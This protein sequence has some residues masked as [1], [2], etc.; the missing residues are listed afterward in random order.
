L[1]LLDS[2]L[3][4]D[5]LVR[6]GIRVY[7]EVAQRLDNYVDLAA[8]TPDRHDAVNEGIALAGRVGDIYGTPLGSA[9]PDVKDAWY[10]IYEAERELRRA[11]AR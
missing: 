3:T 9:F 10:V 1:P 7:L 4:N 6:L 8:E 11:V 2:E 5:Q